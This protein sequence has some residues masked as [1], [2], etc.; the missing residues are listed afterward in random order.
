MKYKIY[1]KRV[2]TKIKIK[3]KIKVYKSIEKK[4]ISV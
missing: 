1:I 3:I 4:N 2:D